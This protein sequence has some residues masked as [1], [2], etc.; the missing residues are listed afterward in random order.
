MP[1]LINVGTYCPLRRCYASAERQ[2]WRGR[3]TDL[4]ADDNSV[5]DAHAHTRGHPHG[6]QGESPTVSFNDLHCA[7]R[8]FDL[9]PGFVFLKPDDRRGES[10]RGCLAIPRRTRSARGSALTL[11]PPRMPALALLCEHPEVRESQVCEGCAIRSLIGTPRPDRRYV[12]RQKRR[13]SNEIAGPIGRRT[14]KYY[15]RRSWRRRLRLITAPTTASRT[16]KM[17][18]GSGPIPATNMNSPTTSTTIAGQNIRPDTAL[19]PL[20]DIVRRTRRGTH[21]HI[22]TDPG[23]L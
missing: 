14:Q 19:S 23:R 6:V 2:I 18:S 4:C 22:G 9:S 12:R 11:H 16:T 10:T 17:S 1:C 21:A 5:G 8:P 3:S 20:E 7:S 15:E 13:A